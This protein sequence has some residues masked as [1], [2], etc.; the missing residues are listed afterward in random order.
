MREWTFGR[1]MFTNI[2]ADIFGLDVSWSSAFSCSITQAHIHAYTHTFIRL[3]V[4]RRSFD[5]NLK[6]T[7]QEGKQSGV[8]LILEPVKYVADW[9]GRQT[10][11]GNVV[12][13]SHMC[14]V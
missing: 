9:S 13:A 5:W 3:C 7:D 14:C 11:G 4:C 1:R 10:K 6:T 8:N 2:L 12:V